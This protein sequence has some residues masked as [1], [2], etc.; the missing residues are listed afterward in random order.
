MC[1]QKMLHIYHCHHNLTFST[2]IGQFGALK[3]VW[4]IGKIVWS[5]IIVSHIRVHRTR[6]LVVSF[7]TIL[8][9]KTRPFWGFQRDLSFLKKN[10]NI[11]VHR[12]PYIKNNKSYIL[13]S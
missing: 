5:D 1:N 6:F 11:S 7:N 3:N 9:S 4:H 8:T 2:A 10:I 12:P 13:T